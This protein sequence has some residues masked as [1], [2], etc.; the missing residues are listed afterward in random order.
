MDTNDTI[1][2]GFEFTP[3]E[4]LAGVFKNAWDITLKTGESYL[5]RMIPIWLGVEPALNEG[6]PAVTTQ[7]PP[8]GETISWKTIGIVF[9][10]AFGAILLIY[11]AK[12]AL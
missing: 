12:K 11:V 7:P 9:G 3:V 5:E 2:G 6:E 8:Q 4:D 10:V 1:S